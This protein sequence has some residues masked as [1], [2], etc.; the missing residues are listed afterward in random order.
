MLE[1]IERQA[2]KDMRTA[3]QRFADWADAASPGARHI[4]VHSDQQK[5]QL[6]FA[7]CDNKKTG[8]LR[9]IIR[10]FDAPNTEGIILEG[11]KKPLKNIQFPVK[12]LGMPCSEYTTAGW[13]SVSS[14]ALR[15]LVDSGVVEGFFSKDG[16]DKEAGVEAAKSIE[17][18]PT[19]MPHPIPQP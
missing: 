9:P 15:K 2:E 16:V 11:K 3:H 6:L 7:P 1:D 8:E 5:Q 13:P 14:S 12:G 10:E 17:A 4:N 18:A 19:Y